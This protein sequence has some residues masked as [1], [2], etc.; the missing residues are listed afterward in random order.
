[1]KSV[2]KVWIIITFL[3]SIF[4]IA[5]FWPRY[6]DNEF[7]LFSDIMMILVFLPS[8]FIL[9]FSIFSFIINQWF[10]KKTGLKLCTSAVLYSMSYYSLYVIFD[11]IWSV[12]MRF[13]LISLTSLAGLIHYMITYGLMFK[14]IKNS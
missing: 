12:N 9:F 3:I 13:M 5:I 6:V 11:D 14:G 1:M 4:S 10:I 7:P 8:F 2:L